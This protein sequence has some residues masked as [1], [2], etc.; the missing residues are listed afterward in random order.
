MLSVAFKQTFLLGVG[1]PSHLVS[2]NSA[3]ACTQSSEALPSTIP[4]CS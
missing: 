1:G 4:R 3:S 2:R